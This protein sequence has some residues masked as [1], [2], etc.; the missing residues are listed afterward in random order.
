MAVTEQRKGEEEEVKR[1]KRTKEI[2]VGPYTQKTNGTIKCQIRVVWLV[3][4]AEP[5]SVLYG[6]FF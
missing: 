6:N 5:F 3:I 4:I 1:R 2:G